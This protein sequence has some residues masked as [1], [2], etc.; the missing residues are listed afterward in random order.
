MIFGR[1]HTFT[2]HPLAVYEDIS[3]DEKE[4]PPNILRE[5]LKNVNSAREFHEKSE[6][7]FKT[8]DNF[9]QENYLETM[10][11]MIVQNWFI[12]KFWPHPFLVQSLWK[13]AF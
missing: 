13:T 5:E 3:D 8:L 11:D 2:G 7:V 6:E 12:Y 1:L 4:T 9:K 10:R